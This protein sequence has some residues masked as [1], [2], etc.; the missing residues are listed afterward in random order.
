M[1]LV[2][3]A[4]KRSL[5]AWSTS[6]PMRGYHFYM[7]ASPCTRKTCNV[8]AR[9]RKIGFSNQSGVFEASSVSGLRITADIRYRLV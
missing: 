7:L 5:W 1:E 9:T 4:R 8:D 6:S 2:I 3:P